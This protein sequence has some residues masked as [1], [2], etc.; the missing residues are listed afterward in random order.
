MKR[1][2]MA[3]LGLALGFR[4]RHAL[5]RLAAKAA[6]HPKRTWH[7]AKGGKTAVSA[8]QRLRSSDEAQERFSRGGSAIARAAG[9]ARAVGARRA[10]SDNDLLDELR[11]A[12]AQLTAAV[13]AM[14]TTPGHRY[15]GRGIMLRS[16]IGGGAG[17]LGYRL[18]KRRAPSPPR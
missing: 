5:V 17:Y 6:R 10:V 9:R 18:W 8:A 15:R 7:V 3:K 2:R 14:Q 4:Y 16:M 12:T 11:E 1:T 13:E